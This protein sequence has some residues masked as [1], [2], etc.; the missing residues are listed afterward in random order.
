M[1]TTTEQASGRRPIRWGI[2]ATG[3]IAHAFARD[4][5]SY[6]H[7]VQAVGSRSQQSADAFAAEYGIPTAHDSYEKLVADPDVDIVY[8]STPHP[9]HAENAELALGAGK[10]VLIEKPITLNA[11][12]AQRIADLAAEK[13]L[14]L[15]EAM[16][17]RFLPH[18]VR[19]REIIAA[20]T[21]G[22]V[23]A[24]LADH[25]QLITDDPEHRLNN[26]ALGGGAL[27]DLGIYPISFAAMLFGSP[28]S[29][30]ATGTLRETGADAQVSAVFRYA[31]GAIAST[32]SASNTKGPNTASILGTNGRID[33]DAV[34]YSPT[35]FRVYNG[36]GD[37]IEAWENTVPERG[38]Q[39]QADEAERL[40]H[41]GAIASSILSPAES[42]SIMQTLDEVR[43][44]IGVVYPAESQRDA[45]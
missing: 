17:T 33:I 12:E 41:D 1:E 29:V 31:D 10:H 39:F 7:I 19:I 6:G 35:T 25:T 13:N 14:L 27:L 16:W 30:T 21:I 37:V 20:G 43:R 38:M 28:E 36:S 34:W 45:G 5:V 24:F 44:Q 18:V 9:F 32:Y 3:G 11:A 22:D 23:R 42:V 15:L 8:I 2:L 4:L 40:I 26:L